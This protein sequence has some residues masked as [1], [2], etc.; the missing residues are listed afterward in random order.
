[1]PESCQF[2]AEEEAW[3]AGNIPVQQRQRLAV[4]ASATLPVRLAG[5][6]VDGSPR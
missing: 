5:A 4:D 1:M 3:R 6:E 2:A